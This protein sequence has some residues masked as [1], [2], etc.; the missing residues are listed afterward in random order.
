MRN[1]NI[2]WE[3]AVIG[4]ILCDPSTIETASEL[5][6]SDFTGCHQIIWAE[7]LSLHQRDALEI[8]ALV[9]SLRSSNQLDSLGSMD[10]GDIRG[11]A[12]VADIM[13]SRGEAVDEY[14]TRVLGASIKRQLA[15]LG[16]LIRAEAEDDRITAE[17]ASD[18]AEQRLMGLRRNRMAGTGVT[19]GD[20][21][22]VYMPRLDG[23]RAGE[24]QPAW[25]P[26]ISALRNVI[27]YAEQEDFILVAARPGEGKSS[28]LRFEAHALAQRQ[29]PVVI[30]NLENSQIEYARSFLALRTGIDST[31]LKT[32]RLLSEEQMD[33]IRHEA[34]RL[35][36]M[37]LHVVTLGAPSIDE[38]ERIS[39]HYIS[40]FGI[41]MIML[42]YIQLVDNGAKSKVDDVSISSQ[43][44]RAMALRYNVP[45]M[46][47]AQL[48]REIVK[49]GDDAEPELSDLRNSGSLEQD[50]TIAMF[51][52]FVW[53]N[54]T[55][56][57]MAAFPENVDENGNL[58]P[59]VKAAPIHI[60]V[61]KNRN[62]PTS[63]TEP[64]LWVKSTGEFRTLV[65]G[66]MNNDN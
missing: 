53:K 48:S 31:L 1:P 45:V 61:K 55:P 7:M 16:A 56:N 52:R 46:A 8:R 27:Q 2:G 17:E 18:H 38:V 54:P 10:G 35:A 43:G 49:R 14:A 36:R 40:H 51:P 9:E 42:D 39:R 6:P 20:I 28:L 22:A 23:L 30:F 37:P 3:K 47:A 59:G 32:P 34:E 33:L 21:L 41:K 5:L 26:N 24:I 58:Y 15:M 13:G 60:F 19:I 25:T 63:T 57:Q 50:A 66:S 11:E 44:A 12:Y 65:R 29:T 64:I 62:G 4:T